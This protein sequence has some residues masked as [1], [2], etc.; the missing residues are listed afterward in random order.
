MAISLDKAFGIHEAALRIRAQRV[1]ILAANMANADTPNY[2]ARDIDFNAALKQ[3]TSGREA[4]NMG[5]THKG[6]IRGVS[7]GVSAEHIKYRIPQQPS[8]DGNT[9]ES[10]IEQ[11]EFTKNAVKYQASLQFFDGRIKGLKKAIKGGD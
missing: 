2:K 1:E 7:S 9:V 8:L 5:V 3:A 6:H 10:H 4:I 11:A